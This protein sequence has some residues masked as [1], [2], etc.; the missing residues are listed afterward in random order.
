[1]CGIVAS[2]STRIRVNADG[3]RR[4]VVTLANGDFDADRVIK[5]AFLIGLA[6][7]LMPVV[8]RAQEKV[9]IDTDFTSAGDDGQVGVMAAQLHAA[10]TIQLLGI[11]IVAGN[12]WLPQEVA[13]ALR[14]VERLGI[15]EEV[16]VYAGARYPLVHDY[17]NLAQER[18]LWGVGGSWYRRPEPPDDALTAPFDGFARRTRVRPQHAVNFIIDTIKKHPREVTLLVIGPMTNI[19]LAIRMNPEIVPLIKRIVYM[20]GAFEVPGNTTPAAEMNVWYDPEAARIV[21]RQAI[22]QAFIP[23]DVT[24]TVPMTKPIF[25]RVMGAGDTPIAKLMASSGLARRFNENP[26]AISYIYDTLALAYLTDPTYAT[27]VKEMWVDVDCTWG[28]S[29][30]RTLG[31]EEELPA[32][33]LQKAKVVRR[34]D[35]DRFFKLYVDLMTRPVPVR[36]RDSAIARPERPE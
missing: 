6:L 4:A 23:L 2:V 29:Y 20:A 33:L 36:L 5:P 27:D 9:I 21:V 25:E 13:D 7:I 26:A 1:V 8:A 34:F 35:N 15:A 10:G 24:N 18:A 28:P 17:N 16:G 22:D 12:E 11:T 14:A 31:Y 30:G 19:A 32:K 3:L